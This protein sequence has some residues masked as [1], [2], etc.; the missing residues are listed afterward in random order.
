MNVKFL[1][2]WVAALLVLPL[3][4]QAASESAAPGPAPDSHI[5]CHTTGDIDFTKLGWT[6]DPL[7]GGERVDSS[8][9]AMLK[10][11][12]SNRLD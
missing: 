5:D 1:A 8:E 10:Q 3:A 4:T 7:Q 6:A 2:A 11:P 9:S 12:T